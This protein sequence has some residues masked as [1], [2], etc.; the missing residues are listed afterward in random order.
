MRQYC[1]VHMREQQTHR[2]ARSTAH[3]LLGIS[4]RGARFCYV[5]VEAARR[6]QVRCT[7]SWIGVPGDRL[8]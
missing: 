7:Q 4:W 5:L 6:A 2:G 3:L 8:T 1:P